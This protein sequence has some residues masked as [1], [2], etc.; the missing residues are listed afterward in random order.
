MKFDRAQINELLQEDNRS[1]TFDGTG[2]GTAVLGIMAGNGNASREQNVGMAPNADIVAVKMG[3]PTQKGFARTTQLMTAIDYVVGIAIA[4]GKPLVIN[5]S[6]GNNY[7]DHRG[8]TI[9]ERYIDAISNY[10]QISI[11]SGIG[12]E[13]LSARHAAGTL[14]SGF[15]NR[16]SEEIEF[17][18]DSYMTSFNLQLWKSFNDR[19]DVYIETPYNT[20]IGPFSPY[21]QVVNYTLTNDLISVIWSEPTPYNSNQ[22]LYV[23]F[24]ARDRYMTPGI[25]KMILVPE[26]ITDGNYDLWLPVFGST[27]ADVSFLTPELNNTAVIPSTAQRVITVSAYDSVNGV[28]A[29]FSGRGPRGY[30]VLPLYQKPDLAAPGVSINTCSVGGGYQ[31]VTGTSFAAPFVSGAAALLMEYGIVRGNDPYLYGEKLR[32]SLIRGA[33]P[34]PFQNTVPDNLVGYG[35]LCVENVF[36]V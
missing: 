6:Y 4:Q 26:M 14:T 3:T 30:N 25:W 21:S 7:G 27:T 22:E 24:V 9:V 5:I 19:V 31:E 32:A 23:S 15:G 8:D 1:L 33:V 12:N 29:P 11:V 20:R 16:N 34:F 28:Y 35:R 13:G 17:V 18:V 10:Y 36:M 2:H